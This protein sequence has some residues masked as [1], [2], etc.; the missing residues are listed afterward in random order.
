MNRLISLF[1]S[2]RVLA[3]FSFFTII[4]LVTA[5]KSKGFYHWDEQYQIVE[6][7][8]YKLGETPQ[9]N[10]AWEFP[11]QIRPGL[12]PFIAYAVFKVMMKIGIESPFTQVMLLRFMS[13][14]LSLF[15]SFFVFL[16]LKN[17]YKTISA[18]LLALLTC[19]FWFTPFVAVRFSS[20]TWSACFMAIATVV[21]LVYEEQPRQ[22]LL[23][24]A[25]L[26]FG[27]AF[28]FRFQSAMFAAGLLL[29]LVFK[30]KKTIKHIVWFVLPF[31]F[32][33]LIGVLFDRWLYGNFVFTP[34]KYFESNIMKDVA[35]S[36]GVMPWHFYFSQ[37]FIY[38]FLPVSIVLF[39]SVSTFIVWSRKHILS[40]A[41]IVFLLIHT[42]IPH[43]EL[44]FMF[45]LV[46]CLPI[47]FAD[48]LSRFKSLYWQKNIL[49]AF[50]VIN[51]PL[52]LYMSVRP[53]QTEIADIEY[54][55]SHKNTAT[56]YYTLDNPAK[57]YG[58]F[59]ELPAEQSMYHPLDAANVESVL[60]KDSPR[61]L[62]LTNYDYPKIPKEIQSTFKAVN[63][64]SKAEVAYFEFMTGEKDSAEFSRT[65]VQLP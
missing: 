10:L 13:A 44:R 61:Y 38:A 41:V 62:F 64:R 7:A 11:A 22:R 48:V 52:M 51:V 29:W 57:I 56:I 60:H 27:F 40:G 32:V 25:G 4:L 30:Q 43:K 34:Y 21:L 31:T 46:F 47:I 17:K 54:C 50:V 59:Y 15:T 49:I 18:E 58:C 45:P 19:S 36:F 16:Y 42:L 55:N 24:S 33:C 3:I 65:L 35:S 20:E 5:V 9:K 12:Q 63:A 26:M 37:V 1:G 6:F 28:L 2:Y 14:L 8:S 23:M 53:A 39:A